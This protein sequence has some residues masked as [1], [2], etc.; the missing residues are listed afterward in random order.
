MK[1]MI[2][3]YLPEEV[4]MTAPQGGM[5]L[6]LTLPDYL[7]S[8][9]LIGNCIH[10]GIA[11]VPGRSFFTNGEGNQHIR[12]NFSNSNPETIEKGMKILGEEMKKK[13][14][15]TPLNPLHASWKA[16]KGTFS[17]MI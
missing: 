4:K 15:K 11:F 16:G 2:S 6:W 5:F 7:D 1:K 12:M 8:E 10:R 14:P 3:R 17:T 13:V 9:E